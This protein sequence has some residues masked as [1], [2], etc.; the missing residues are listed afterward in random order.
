MALWT[1]LYSAPALVL[2]VSP[3]QRQSGELFRSIMAFYRRLADAPALPAENV[4]R[5][6]FANGSRIISLPGSSVTTRGYSKA[7]LVVID[8]AARVED[9]LIAALRPA[10]A[11][12]EGGGRL[13]ALS[14]PFGRRGW[15]YEAWE[16]GGEDWHRVR[17]PASEC[18]RIS[19]EFLESELKALGLLAF[20]EEYQLE[21]NDSNMAAFNSAIIERAFD[22]TVV[23]LW[24]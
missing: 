14:T 7:S 12:T 2:V 11:V 13:I 22:P 10:M 17:V 3:S 4:L 1:A 6:E 18:P 9:D 16:N 19:P 24:A 8:E 21:F 15:F 5:A 23:P 20:G